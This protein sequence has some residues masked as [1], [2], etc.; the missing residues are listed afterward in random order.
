MACEP[1]D[2]LQVH[3]PGIH[4]PLEKNQK[5]SNLW[6]GS[7]R[8]VTTTFQSP[9]SAI[10]L[11]SILPLLLQSVSITSQVCSPLPCAVMWMENWGFG[12]QCM[13]TQEDFQNKTVPCFTKFKTIDHFSFS[14][15]SR[16][17]PRTIATASALL[18]WI[19]ADFEHCSWQSLPNPRQSCIL[20]NQ[21]YTW[22]MCGHTY[23]YFHQQEGS[24]GNTVCKSVQVT[25]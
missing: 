20:S 17:F 2:F 14:S 5:M 19:R 8:H 7:C 24:C 6:E 18:P 12:R 9:T 13:A 25:I 22:S 16:R 1:Q 23:S 15:S 11:P 21:N 3:F 10:S 4:A